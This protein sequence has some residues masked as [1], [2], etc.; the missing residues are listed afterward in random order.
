MEIIHIKASV[1]KE[2]K[3]DL[4]ADQVHEEKLSAEE[5]AAIEEMAMAASRIV[6][7][8]HDGLAIPVTL[9]HRF[10]YLCYHVF[11]KLQDGGEFE[12]EGKP[13]DLLPKKKAMLSQPLH[14]KSEWEIRRTRE[15]AIKTL[16]GLG[17]EVV[18]T[19]FTDEWYGAETMAERGVRQRPLAF[20]AKSLE[21]M[22]LC[23]AAFFCK[24]WDE[25]RG[26]RI[27][28]EAA[29]QYGLVMLYEEDFK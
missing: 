20:L 5:K 19:L 4:K 25:A 15:K 10:N 18:N 3:E 27:E 28:H 13:A 17:Y 26:C 11:P 7:R 12:P 22:S 6:N 29:K 14:G 24:G 1:S 21:N 8:A 23:D 16:E 9:V 2:V